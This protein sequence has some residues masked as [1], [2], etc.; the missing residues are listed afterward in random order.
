MT[1]LYPTP[2]P[3]R[4]RQS[5]QSH[6]DRALGSRAREDADRLDA[7]VPRP[8]VTL[9]FLASLGGCSLRYRGRDSLPRALADMIS[10][11][12]VISLITPVIR[13]SADMADIKFTDN[14]TLPGSERTRIGWTR[15]RAPDTRRTCRTRAH[16]SGLKKDFTKS[17]CKSK[18]S[19][20]S[21]NV[22]FIFV[23]VKDKLTNLCGNRLLQNDFIDTFC[24]MKSR[25]PPAASQC[26]GS[27]HSHQ[28]RN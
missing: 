13:F 6:A 15:R 8:R 3:N 25:C 22:L 23:I 7:T 27:A 10:A 19:H 24:E 16:R 1:N 5:S 9:D 28:P 26:S 14:T 21:V 4:L 11:R 20:K 2:C 17:F 12:K 18:F